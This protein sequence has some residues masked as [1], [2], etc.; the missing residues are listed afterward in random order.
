MV[1]FRQV[2][3]PFRDRSCFFDRFVFH[4]MAKWWHQQV[5]CLFVHCPNA[6][7]VLQ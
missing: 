7:D 5:V 3:E 6:A 2:I 4:F 1:L